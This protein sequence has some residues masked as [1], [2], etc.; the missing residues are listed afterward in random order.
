M[1]RVL[2]V[3]DEDIARMSLADILDLEGYDIRTASNGQEAV[4]IINKEPPDVVVL[5]LKM[6]GLSGIQVLERIEDK[7]NDVKVIV[8]TAHGSMDSAIQA[9]RFRV[10]DYL[11]KPVEPQQLVDCIEGAMVSKASLMPSEDPE[12]PQRYYRLTPEITMDINK[13]VIQWGENEMSLTPTEAKLMLL[14]T[15]SVGEMRTHTDLVLNCQGYN[16]NNE[17]AAK[18]LRPVVSRLRQKMAALPG[19]NEWIRNIRGAGYVLELPKQ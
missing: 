13:R 11:L 16:V 15:E 19:W 10:H 2:I 12:K 7:L 8:L 14:L 17:E 6:P 18:I 9:L 3:D 1:I 4:D 5:D